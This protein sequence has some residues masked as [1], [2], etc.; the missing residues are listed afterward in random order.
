MLAKRRANFIAKQANYHPMNRQHEHSAAGERK[1]TLPTVTDTNNCQSAFLGACPQF[2]HLLSPLKSFDSFG[3][4]GRF[5]QTPL[6]AQFKLFP[7]S[8]AAYN[9]L[10]IG[11]PVQ[12]RRK[13]PRALEA[14]DVYPGDRS[15]GKHR[16]RGRG[17][18][19]SPQTGH[20]RFPLPKFES[21]RENHG[22]GTRDPD[23]SSGSP[24]PCRT[25]AGLDAPERAGR[26]RLLRPLNRERCEPQFERAF[27]KRPLHLLVHPI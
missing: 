1:S 21:W 18:L 2:C 9:S 24:S 11:A 25:A 7:R 20:R 12:D 22:V 5:S 13:H 4:R 17:K 15:V 10:P 6:T 3:A 14:R 26:D 8:G 16:R 27:I 23:V 19:P